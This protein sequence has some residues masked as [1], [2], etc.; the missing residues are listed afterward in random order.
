MENIFSFVGFDQ[1]LGLPLFYDDGRR[2]SPKMGFKPV[3]ARLSSSNPPPK[4]GDSS[5]I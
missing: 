4:I 2:P 5:I 1:R 3:L